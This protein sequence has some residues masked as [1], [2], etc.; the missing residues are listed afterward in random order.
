MARLK[1]RTHKRIDINGKAFSYFNQY[2]IDCAFGVSDFVGCK[3]VAYRVQGFESE[4]HFSDTV[5]ERVTIGTYGDLAPA[6]NSLTEQ[7]FIITDSDF[8]GKRVPTDKAP[9]HYVLRM[10]KHSKHGYHGHAWFFNCLRNVDLWHDAAGRV[11]LQNLGWFEGALFNASVL[12][13]DTMPGALVVP[14]RG[15]TK[16]TA[17]AFAPASWGIGNASI[18]NGIARAVQRHDQRLFAIRGLVQGLLDQSLHGMNYARDW[19]GLGVDFNPKDIKPKLQPVLNLGEAAYQKL[20][21]LLNDGKPEVD[22]KALKPLFRF[23]PSEM[24]MI[25]KALAMKTAWE[26]DQE[27][28]GKIQ[29]YTFAPDGLEYFKNEAVDQMIEMVEKY[30]ASAS[31][32]LDADYK[33]PIMVEASQE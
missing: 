9:S 11:R 22:G 27:T 23:G 29:T 2:V 33:T 14:Q 21:D 15:G 20:R 25:A 7:S 8:Q 5:F 26:K 3:D 16:E 6:G 32:L 12:H 17:Q 10:K 24:Q 13:W 1:A 19:E 18:A 31:E 4:F 30:I 28:W